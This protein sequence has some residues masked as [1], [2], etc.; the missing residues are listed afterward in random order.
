MITHPPARTLWF[1]T[2][3]CVSIVSTTISSAQTTWVRKVAGNGL[4]NPFCVN[5]WNDNVIYGA[6]GGNALYISRDRGNSWQILSVVSGGTAIK[7]VAVS[8]SDT[9]IILVAQEAGPPDRIM[10]T[11]NNGATLFSMQQ[12]HSLYDGKQYRLSEH[13][14]R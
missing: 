4:G 2:F 5:P 1:L 9:N 6:V 11:T 3:L 13:E 8:A 7:S 10:K 14:L 12:R